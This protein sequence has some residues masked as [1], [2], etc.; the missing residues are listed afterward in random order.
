M[1]CFAGGQRPEREKERSA[2]DDTSSKHF[3]Y[4]CNINIYIYVTIYAFGP[5]F[6]GAAERRHV[7]ALS[8]AGSKGVT[9][10]A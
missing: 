10:R 3:D 5:T 7:F 1:G 8:K 6:F 2:A 9:A 4:T